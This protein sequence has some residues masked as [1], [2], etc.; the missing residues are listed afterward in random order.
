MSDR[1]SLASRNIG[2]V[3]TLLGVADSLENVNTTIL[4]DGS[5]A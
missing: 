1:S 2:S 3:G 4:D 5:F